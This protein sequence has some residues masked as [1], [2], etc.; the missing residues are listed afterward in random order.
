MNLTEFIEQTGIQCKEGEEFTHSPEFFKENEFQ[1]T[2][3]VIYGIPFLEPET[4]QVKEFDVMLRG[5]V[6]EKWDKHEKRT[7]RQFFVN[8]SFRYPGMEEGFDIIE[9]A[10]QRQLLLPFNDN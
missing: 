7:K 4:Y 8:R 1:K 6:Q 2:C 3:H 5:F 9:D 10:D